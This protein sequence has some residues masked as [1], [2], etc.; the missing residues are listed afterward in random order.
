MLDLTHGIAVAKPRTMKSTSTSFR[1]HLIRRIALATGLSMAL[2]SA[3]SLGGCDDGME[4][5]DWSEGVCPD[6]DTAINHFELECGEFVQSVDSDA[7]EGNAECCYDVTIE[8]NDNACCGGF[9][10][11]GGAC[12]VD[13]RPLRIDGDAVTARSVQ[14]SGWCDAA[15]PE[16]DGLDDA[17]RQVLADRWTRAALDEHASV[18]S[19]ARFALDLMALGAPSDLV[20]AA[21]Q[22]G[23]DEVHHARLSFALASAFAGEQ[24]GPSALAIPDQLTIEKDLSAFAVATAIDACIN[25]T[26]A[27]LV[28]SEARAQA[29]DEAVARVLDEVVEDEA[30]HAELA[31]AALAWAIDRGGDAVRRAVTEAIAGYDPLAMAND[32]Q[33]SVPSHGMI[34]AADRRA[35]LVRGFQE[36]VAPAMRALLAPKP[37]R[38]LKTSARAGLSGPR[39]RSGT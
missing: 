24:R 21:Q 29:T 39:S 30:R 2:V 20:A 36:V 4:C 23:L 35:A 16:L 9:D 37:E 3:V 1:R 6:R 8:E 27:V 15:H 38:Q 26:L 5:F 32:A 28:A 18:A 7:F 13:G 11:F 22:A 17:Q 25:E 19:F 34:A 10:P 31:W 33:S 12:A 14:R